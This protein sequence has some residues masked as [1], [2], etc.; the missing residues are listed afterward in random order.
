MFGALWFGT[1]NHHRPI[2]LAAFRASGAGDADARSLV[3]QEVAAVS[4]RSDPLIQ[5]LRK[6][7]VAGGN[8]FGGPLRVEGCHAIAEWPERGMI[9]HIPCGHRLGL[10]LRDAIENRIARYFAFAVLTSKG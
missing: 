5:R 7:V 4:I 2:G 10:L 1:R 9:H 3:H 8:V 6:R